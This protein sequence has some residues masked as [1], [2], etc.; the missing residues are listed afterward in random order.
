MTRAQRTGAIDAGDVL[1]VTVLGTQLIRLVAAVAGG[2]AVAGNPAD[3][4]PGRFHTGA[5]IAEFGTAGDGV[6]VLLLLLAVAVLC[7]RASGARPATAEPRFERLRATTGWLLTLT[8]ISA[9]AALVGL[10][11]QASGAGFLNWQRLVSLDGFQVAYLVAAL[12]AL[13]VVHRLSTDAAAGDEADDEPAAVFAVDRRTGGVLAWWSV[14]EAE[15][16]APL[17][18]VEDDEYEWYLDDGVV[19]SAAADARDVRLTV[20]AESRPDEL[21]A[22]LQ[23]YAQRRGLDVQETHEPLSYVEPIARDHY[24]EMWPGWLRWI[25]RLT[26]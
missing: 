14:R 22:V 9:V 2:I 19:L 11:V 7:W 4:E 21:L 23:E 20:T 3:Y 8:A 17:Y 18:G 10:T 26:H 24:L 1:L 5:T 12:G 16:N 13:A 15:D 25:G 6:G